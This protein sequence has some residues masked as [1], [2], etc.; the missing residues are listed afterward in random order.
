MYSTM[1]SMLSTFHKA[2]SL[3]LRLSSVSFLRASLPFLVLFG[4]ICFQCWLAPR[5][6]DGLGD[7]DIGLDLY[8]NSA[9]SASSSRHSES[10]WPYLFS[11]AEAN[12]VIMSDDDATPAANNPGVMKLREL[13]R[14]SS[15]SPEKFL[16]YL[17][18]ADYR[19]FVLS[20]PRP[21]RLFVAFYTSDPKY[22]PSCGTFISNFREVAEAY[23]MS[24]QYKK[25]KT[26][27]A[28]VFAVFDLM[29]DKTIAALHQL[30]QV[31]TLVTFDAATEE[32][33]KSDSAKKGWTKSGEQLLFPANNVFEILQA[34]LD[35]K[36][37][38]VA[39]PQ[40]VLEWTNLQS[41]RVDVKLF[42]GTFQQIKGIG[43][44]C[45]VLCVLSLVGW[46]VVGYLRRWPITVV[47]G[48]LLLQFLGTSGV[49]Y[50]FQNGF[51]WTGIDRASKTVTL[52]AR[53]TRMQFAFEGFLMAGTTVMCGLWLVGLVHVEQLSGLAW[54]PLTLMGFGRKKPGSGDNEMRGL[55]VVRQLVA[56]V[57]GVLFIVGVMATFEV[58][59]LKSPWYAPTFY[60]PAD[61]VKG[62]MRNDRGN[63]F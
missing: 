17:S 6:S 1:S 51:V 3:V 7:I 40:R 29:Q 60:P 58:F 11:V 12:S 47:I 25:T 19:S 44:L 5:T 27:P 62:P 35:H 4:M 57:L 8:T 31:P 55:G 48:G 13:L 54:V 63:V 49:F 50:S 46:M 42:V 24:G 10:G 33:W 37:V 30:R 21:Y 36:G 16:A 26:H 14:L 41:G 39:L 18:P 9:S 20:A 2:Q 34:G 56:C 28:V 22:C 59:R 15:L 52:I 23:I 38:S 32:H 53:S 61:Y 43:L 45:L